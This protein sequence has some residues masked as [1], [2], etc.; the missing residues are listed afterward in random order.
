VSPIPVAVSWSGG[1]SA[2]LA[3]DRVLRDDRYRVEALL[4]VVDAYRDRVLTNDV[5]RALAEEQ[6]QALDLPME[7]AP[8]PGQADERVSMLMMHQVLRRLRAERGVKGVVYGD[9]FQAEARAFRESHL[10]AAGFEAV[11]PLWH[12]ST[13][14]LAHEF[15]E[16]GYGGVVVRVDHEQLDDHF[17]GR[18]LNRHFFRELPGG[19]DPCGENGEFHSFVTAAPH[20]AFDLHVAP[21]PPVRQGRFVTC[22]LR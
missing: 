10:A 12:E 8:L 6:A 17:C 22:D 11:F 3:L 1:Q 18:R 13:R 19:V 2:A 20:F 9:I 7:L 5:P 21:Q 15:C 4:C 14:Q 16:R